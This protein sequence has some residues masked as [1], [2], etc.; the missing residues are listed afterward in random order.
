MVHCCRFYKCFYFICGIIWIVG[1]L[2]TLCFW[3]ICILLMKNRLD[4][5]FLY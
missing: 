4:V 1:R 2:K 5:D 3:F